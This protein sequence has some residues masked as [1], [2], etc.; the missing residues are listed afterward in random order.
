M[1]IVFATTSA[2]VTNT[3][4]ISGGGVYIKDSPV[5]VWSTSDFSA[6]NATNSGGGIGTDNSAI[7]VSASTINRNS[8]GNKGGGGIRLLFSDGAI[9]SGNTFMLNIVSVGNA[10]A[11]FLERSNATV[12]GNTMISNT[13]GSGG[14]MYIFFSNDA[15]VSGN[16][17]RGNSATTDGGGIVLQSTTIKLVNNV[18]VDNRLTIGSAKGSGIFVQQSA[19]RLLHNTIARNTGGDNSGLSFSTL[20]PAAPLVMTN[21]II[22]SQSVGITTTAGNTVTVLGVLF[23]GNGTN[24][25]GAGPINITNQHNGNPLFAADGYHILPGSGAI[26]NG[27]NTGVT[28]DIDGDSRPQGATPDLGADELLPLPDVSITKIGPSL[29]ISPSNSFAAVVYTIILTNVGGSTLTNIVVTDTV[30]SGMI[31][32]QPARPIVQ[33]IAG[34][35]QLHGQ[36]AERWRDQGVHHHSQGDYAARVWYA[37]GQSGDC[38]CPR[39]GIPT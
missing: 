15:T 19:A 8:A 11:V 17:M 4:T 31:A 37:D 25:T 28:T 16:V 27:I 13:A 21:T 23:F 2:I 5:V 6:N 29:I 22:V 1:T 24:T 33:P 3:A 39:R 34:G 18:I 30:P 38:R 26:D 32:V 7:Q 10:G 36:P 20:I 35:R 12:A 9:V 14:A